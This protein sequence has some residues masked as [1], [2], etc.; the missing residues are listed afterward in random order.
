MAAKPG[1]SH[2]RHLRAM[3]ADESVPRRSDHVDWMGDPGITEIKRRTGCRQYEQV[4]RAEGLAG[5]HPLSGQAEG[6]AED[7]LSQSLRTGGGEPQLEAAPERM[8][9]SRDLVETEMVEGGNQMAQGPLRCPRSRDVVEVRNDDSDVATV[10]E[11]LG[12]PAIRSRGE[13]EAVEKKHRRPSSHIER[14][15]RLDR[16]RTDGPNPGR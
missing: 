15:H 13:P 10:G 8:A 7:Q 3:I 6:V 2:G 12:A 1:P 14:P 9:Y 5:Q 4:D 11:S 16:E